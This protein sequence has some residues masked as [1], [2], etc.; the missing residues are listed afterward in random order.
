MLE[1]NLRLDSEF[2]GLSKSEDTKEVEQVYS[3]YSD[4]KRTLDCFSFNLVVQVHTWI[5]L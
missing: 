2:L 3:Y 1:K 5:C 4:A